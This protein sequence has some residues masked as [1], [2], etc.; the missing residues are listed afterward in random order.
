MACQLGARDKATEPSVI[1]TP[2]RARHAWRDLTEPKQP[3]KQKYD[4]QTSSRFIQVIYII[5]GVSVLLHDFFLDRIMMSFGVTSV[6]LNI[7]F[8]NEEIYI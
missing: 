6:F 2:C 5:I 8:L 3:F 1:P 7:V 4:A